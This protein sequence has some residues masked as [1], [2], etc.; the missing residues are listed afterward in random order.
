[1]ERRRAEFSLGDGVVGQ[2]MRHKAAGL[3]S[4]SP[5][6]VWVLTSF[7]VTALNTQ[8]LW[9]E[10]GFPVPVRAHFVVNLFLQ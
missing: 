10:M 7:G 8:L 3:V 2:G 5:L 9:L 4:W 1:M 6:A